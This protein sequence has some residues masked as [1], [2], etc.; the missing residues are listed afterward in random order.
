MIWQPSTTQNALKSSVE[1]QA[2]CGLDGLADES[3][4]SATYNSI[5]HESQSIKVKNKDY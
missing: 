2:E 1:W 4:L 5:T 3:R